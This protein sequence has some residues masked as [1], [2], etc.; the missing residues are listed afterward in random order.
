MTHELP[1]RVTPT[2]YLD[3]RVDIADPAL[4][5]SYDELSFWSSRFGRLLYENI[6]LLPNV[7]ALDLGCGTGFPL[8][9]LAHMHGPHS[10]FVGADIWAHALRRAESKR[11]FYRLD[12]V[13]LIRSDGVHLPFRD[14]SFD[15]ITSNLGVN[16]FADPSGAFRECFRVSR[17]A[18]RLAL[19]TNIS[20]H[21]REFY[22]VFRELLRDLGRREALRR[23]D[24]NESHRGTKESLAELL[25]E[26]GFEIVRAIED[27]FEMR[28]LDGR[29][30]LG[31]AL[32][33]IGFLDG[34]KA[35]PDPNEVAHVFRL[36]EARLDEL[37]RN[38][39]GLSMTVPMLY[40]EGR[41][42]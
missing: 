28:Y 30:L 35:V 34:W 19:A 23:L 18:G 31:H 3:K 17:R 15:L 16:N 33:W 24:A 32:T 25:S 8:F 13:A 42:A 38:R 4:A 27:E 37:A 39:G 22:A 10:T 21:M 1:E 36:L 20:G 26:A 40:L 12:R 11:R 2:H 14:E 6:E 7:R 41:R 5:S 29:A 9:E